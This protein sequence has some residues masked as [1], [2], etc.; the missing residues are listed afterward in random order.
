MR[1]LIVKDNIALFITLSSNASM[2]YAIAMTQASKNAQP[3]KCEPFR[4]TF[5]N[6]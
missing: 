3:A 5:F 4:Q 6:D 2:Q 1:S